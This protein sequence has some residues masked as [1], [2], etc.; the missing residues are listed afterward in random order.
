MKT[1]FLLLLAA[2]LLTF[3][4]FSQFVCGFDDVHRRKLKDD[5]QYRLSVAD[6][7]KKIQQYITR[8]RQS[9]T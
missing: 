6:N 4:V 1:R 3:P 7:E 9:L 8:N 5:P 2:S